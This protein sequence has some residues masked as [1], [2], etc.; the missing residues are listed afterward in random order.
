VRAFRT[1]GDLAQR[2]GLTLDSGSDV[3]ALP[4]SEGQML[5][6]LADDWRR[7]RLPLQVQSAGCRAS[8]PPLVGAVNVAGLRATRR[9]LLLDHSSNNSGVALLIVRTTAAFTET[10]LAKTPLEASP[11][12]LQI[13][14]EVFSAFPAVQP[15]SASGFVQYPGSSADWLPIVLLP[16]ETIFWATVAV[17][18]TM[19][20]TFAWKELA[21]GEDVL[22]SKS[23]AV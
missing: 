7:G 11:S 22:T 23:P 18:Q 12:Q 6:T 1:L 19:D 17:N 9:P 20:L 15:F 16:G 21:T 13:T 14:A 5:V 10:V 4:Y 3:R 8:L 2:L